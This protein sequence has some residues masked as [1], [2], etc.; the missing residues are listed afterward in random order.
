[1]IE[2]ICTIHNADCIGSLVRDNS[3]VLE[4]S[5]VGMKCDLNAMSYA[6]NEGGLGET[7]RLEYE[8]V[9]ELYQELRALKEATGVK[10]PAGVG[11]GGA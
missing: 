6:L 1:M 8:R 5:V 3:A 4:Y 2:R 9:D 10:E 7:I 11:G